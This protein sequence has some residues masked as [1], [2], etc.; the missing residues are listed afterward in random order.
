LEPFR[1]SDD[2]RK[3]GYTMYLYGA[4]G[5]VSRLYGIKP[6]KIP[7]LDI[8]S[9]NTDI[10]IASVVGILIF[11]MSVIYLLRCLFEYNLNKRNSLAEG[12]KKLNE[13][14]TVEEIFGVTKIV[15]LRALQ[16]EM[17]DETVKTN[18]I[19]RNAGRAFFIIDI[20]F[21]ISFIGL[22]YFI[23]SPR[24]VALIKALAVSI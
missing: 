17:F 16:Q 9:A 2:L 20:V 1:I 24:T 19:L 14:K 4:V 18:W 5:I 22:C 10:D 3:F 8:S 21:P 13:A 11:Y 23:L 12:V 6:D 7:F 15:N